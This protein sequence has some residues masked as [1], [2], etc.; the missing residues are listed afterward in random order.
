LAATGYGVI[1]EIRGGAR[2]IDCGVIRTPAADKPAMRL[3]AIARAVSQLASRHAPDAACVERVFANRNPKT[4]LAV[5]EAR[6]A[7]IAVLLRAA[8]PVGEVSALQVKQNLTGAGRADKKQVAWMVRRL[9]ALPAAHRLA[10][11]AADALACALGY[12]RQ[13]KKG[14]DFTASNRRRARALADAP[15]NP[16]AA[17]KLEQA[18]RKAALAKAQTESRLSEKI[19]KTAARAATRKK[20]GEI[21][22]GAI[23]GG[24]VEKIALRRRR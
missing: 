17:A 11:D 21:T 16:S 1:R 20:T 8:I 12:A 6:G 13:T 14:G 19:K 9:L 22:A 5:G 15:P 10:P 3:A 7:A 18:R 2:L 4:S 24:A 23:G